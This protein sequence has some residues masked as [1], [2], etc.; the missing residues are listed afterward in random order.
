MPLFKWDL[1]TSE[2][3]IAELASV[4]EGASRRRILILCHNNPDPDTMASAFGLQFLLSKKFNVRS[5]LGYGGVVTRAENQAMVRRLR[6]KMTQM[7]RV[8]PHQYY[9]IAMVDAQPGTGNNLC[10]RGRMA[11]MI[12]IDHHPLRKA[13]LKA[14]FHDI[15]PEYGATSTIIAEYIAAAELTPTRSLANALLYGI[16]TDTDSL[17]RGASRADF[18]AF[19]YLFPFTNPRVVGLIEKPCLSVEY[20]QDYHRGLTNATL[21]KDVA[22]SWLGETHAGAIIPELADLLLRIEGVS[23]VLCFGTS[24]NLLIMSLRSTARLHDAGKVI[25]RLVGKSGAAGGHSR[26]AGGQ[27]PL[28]GMSAEEQA[29]LPERLV[30]KFLKIMGRDGVHPRPLVNTDPDEEKIPN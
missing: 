26:M 17:V 1:C 11:P 14:D 24:D 6:I 8:K 4:V 10:P 22:V 2:D 25:R 28:G 18:L 21:Y 30:C 13:S 5:T 12:V 3:K 16:K 23:S 7:S 20:F 15:R 19:R 27:I 29:R 9:A